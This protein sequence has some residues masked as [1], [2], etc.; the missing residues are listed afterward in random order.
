MPSSITGKF[1][2]KRKSV[3]QVL[4]IWDLFVEF[5]YRRSSGEDI[6]IVF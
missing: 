6:T 2:W 3:V 5:E 4:C 1:G